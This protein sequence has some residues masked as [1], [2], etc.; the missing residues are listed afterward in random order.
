MSIEEDFKNLICLLQEH[1]STNILVK[2]AA[3]FILEG[4]VIYWSFDNDG[5]PGSAK[6]HLLGTYEIRG[7]IEEELRRENPFVVGYKE[8]LPAFRQTKHDFICIS[9][10]TTQQG[11]YLIFSDYAKQDL[12]GILKSKRNLEEIRAVEK[13][14]EANGMEQYK[15]ASFVFIKGVLQK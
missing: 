11:S 12:I 3:Q 7:R 9:D 14:N 15:S 1:Q 10:I 2:E 8:L 13:E 5:K 6:D 4:E